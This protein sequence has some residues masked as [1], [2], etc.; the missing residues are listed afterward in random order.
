MH[1]CVHTHTRARVRVNGGK[2]GGVQV[3]FIITQVGRTVQNF[4]AF[5]VNKLYKF[6]AVYPQSNSAIEYRNRRCA[7]V[8]KK[9]KK[10]KKEIKK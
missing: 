1:M 3:V 10:K 9:K 5:T 2:V 8:S 4:V 7:S 6:V